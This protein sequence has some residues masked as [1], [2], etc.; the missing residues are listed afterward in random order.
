MLVSEHEQVPASMNERKQVP[1][2]I[3]EH[4]RVGVGAGGYEQAQ[5]SVFFQGFIF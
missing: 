1:V 2:S 4:K 5:T 3:N